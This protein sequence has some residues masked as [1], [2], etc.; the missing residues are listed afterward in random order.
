MVHPLPLPHTRSSCY[1][2]RLLSDWESC[3]QLGKPGCSAGEQRCQESKP[4]VLFSSVL[5][6]RERGGWSLEIFSNTFALDW[7][8]W[9]WPSSCSLPMFSFVII[10]LL[11]SNEYLQ[12]GQS[13]RWSGYA[14]CL[15]H[16]M[17][18]PVVHVKCSPVSVH[19]HCSIWHHRG[20][21]R[22]WRSYIQS[23]RT[24][25]ELLKISPRGTLVENLIWRTYKDV[26]QAEAEQ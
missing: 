3:L 19:L 9:V 6:G 5:F 1:Q 15:T 21:C 26:E 7:H 20:L 13:N 16:H 22:G 17:L 24:L 12:H 8:W 18:G 2:T 23:F 10:W 25:V 14:S 11:K 4:H